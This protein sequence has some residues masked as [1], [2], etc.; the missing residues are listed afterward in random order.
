MWSTDTRG[1]L[2]VVKPTPSTTFCICASRT[3][4]ITGAKSGLPALVSSVRKT[5]S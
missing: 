3:W 5:E 2:S 4:A 1:P